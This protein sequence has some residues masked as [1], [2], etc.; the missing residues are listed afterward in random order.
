MGTTHW[1]FPVIS[2]TPRDEKS[3]GSGNQR[4]PGRIGHWSYVIKISLLD[5]WFHE[6]AGI[7]PTRLLRMAS[8]TTLHVA[9]DH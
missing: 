8:S 9:A 1:F 7:T 5:V 2:N 6:I 4:E 3:A